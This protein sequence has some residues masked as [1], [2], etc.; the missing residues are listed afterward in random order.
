MKRKHAQSAVTRRRLFIGATVAAGL[1]CVLCVFLWLLIAHVPSWYR[2]PYV[3]ESRY[4]EVRN[5]ML[6]VVSDFGDR[7]VDGEPFEVVLTDRQLSEWI[8]V[9]GELW[10]ESD[11]WI[12][13]FIRGP[14]VAFRPGRII[15][16]GRLEKDGWQV[17]VSGELRVVVGE[18]SVSVR[19]EQVAG[20]SC[21]VP[22]ATVAGQLQPILAAEGQDIDAMPDYVAEV[23]RRFRE[24]DAAAYLRDGLTTDNRFYWQ[25][26]KRWFRIASLHVEGGR[27][28]IQ[29]E[30]LMP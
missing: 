7:L 11:E 8:A 16:A 15:L 30:P 5:G 19:L 18:K 25:V 9:R 22:V 26:S 10:P 20:G 29:I 3:P 6:D 14:M 12:P 28:R 17:V 27:L 13:P 23:V 24:S 1:F 2:P 4:A 21:P